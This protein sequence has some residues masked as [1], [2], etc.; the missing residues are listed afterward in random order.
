MPWRTTRPPPDSARRAPPQGANSL[1][2]T[3]SCS[4]VRRGARCPTPHHGDVKQ[5]THAYDQDRQVS[6]TKHTGA[7][8][9]NKVG[10]VSVVGLACC[11]KDH[12]ILR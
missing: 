6:Q 2:R 3:P 8:E 10:E 5:G 4:V 11:A 1:L 7:S 12:P 9:F